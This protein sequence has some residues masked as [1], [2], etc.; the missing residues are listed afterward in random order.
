MRTTDGTDPGKPAPPPQQAPSLPPLVTPV[1]QENPWQPVIDSNSTQDERTAAAAYTKVYGGS[2]ASSG[3]ID[4]GPGI[5]SSYGIPNLAMAY[6][7]APDLLA[8]AGLPGGGS[9]AG[10]APTTDTSVVIATSPVS[11]I[12]LSALLDAEQTILT[13]IASCI[14]EYDA[15]ES[16]IK[17]A[18]ASDSLFGQNVGTQQQMRLS[19]EPFDKSRPWLVT[20]DDLDKEGIAMANSIQP[21][22]EYLMQ[23]AAGGLFELWGG[24]AALL[25]NTGQMYASTDYSS[26]LDL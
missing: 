11:H 2:P 18:I 21:Q 16:V 4:T 1:A 6:T 23:V 13:T 10:G 14:T 26:W 12:D 24:F 19:Y 17:N 5:G 9:G 15:A 22:L 8:G 7:R 25:S 3:T 20:Y